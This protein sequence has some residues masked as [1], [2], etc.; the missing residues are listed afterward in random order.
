MPNA[1]LTA[2]TQFLRSEDFYILSNIELHCNMS[3]E[4]FSKWR[5][6]SCYPQCSSEV[7]SENSIMTTFSD[8]FIPAKSLPYGTYRLTLIITMI[9]EPSL[10]LSA[11][12]H[13]TIIPSAIK[14][15][16]IPFGTS[17]I[18]RGYQQD[19]LLNP[20]TFSINPDVD[21]FNTSVS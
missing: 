18:T 10:T 1:P 19:L 9:A 2:P 15:N 12:T 14:A 8:L 20:G 5:I 21:L 7:Q 11:S 13:V 17:M 6:Y 4:M 16:L 3:L